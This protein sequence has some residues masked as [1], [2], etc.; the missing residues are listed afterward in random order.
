[1]RRS[2]WVEVPYFGFLV[3][4]EQMFADLYG[5]SFCWNVQLFVS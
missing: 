5:S 4:L 1:M 3:M 2:L